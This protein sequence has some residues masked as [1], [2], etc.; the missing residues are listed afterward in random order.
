[1][2]ISS[3]LSGAVFVNRRYT[4]YLTRH[5]DLPVFL[6]FGESSEHNGTVSLSHNP[7]GIEA[8]IPTWLFGVLQKQ[9]RILQSIVDDPF[10]LLAV[11]EAKL[12]SN[13]SAFFTIFAKDVEA[14]VRPFTMICMNLC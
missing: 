2:L 9:P 4:G 3:V 12:L 14:A 10:C 6:Y 1:M 13:W 5:Q 7:T 11:V 8:P